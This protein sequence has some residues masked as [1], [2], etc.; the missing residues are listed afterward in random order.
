MIELHNTLQN[1]IWLDPTQIEFMH[2][3]S[4]LDKCGTCTPEVPKDEMSL[5]IHLKSGKTII[6]RECYTKVKELAAGAAQ[7]KRFLG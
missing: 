2:V 5:K 6:V 3:C 4:S 7:A 1:P